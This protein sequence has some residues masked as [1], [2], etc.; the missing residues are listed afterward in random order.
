MRPLGASAWRTRFF[1]VGIAVFA[2]FF[3]FGVYDAAYAFLQRDLPSVGRLE[4]WEPHL[5]T[6]VYAA[7]GSLLAEF[8]SERREMVPL[9]EVPPVVVK[10]LLATEDQW[11]YQH[12]GI[13]YVRLVEAAIH[14]LRTGEA[15]QGASTITQQLARNLFLTPE[16]KLTRKI[17]E[18][19]LA[20]E[21]EA[22]YD[23]DE[24]LEMYLN[25]VYFGSGAYGIESA[26]NLYFGKPARELTLPEAALLVGL[27][28]APGRYS[29][30][31]DLRA[32]IQRRNTV[33]E[34]MREDGLVDFATTR[35]AQAAPIVL[36]QT[37]QADR[38][39]TYF[40][41]YVRSQIEGLF[42]SEAVW[43]E[44][45]RVYTTLDPEL[46]AHAEKV[47][48]QRSR[49]IE[50]MGGFRAYRHVTREQWL[51]RQTAN[52]EAV[53]E[54]AER[55]ETD[56]F[57][58]TPYLQMGLVA[59]DLETGSIRAM[60][61]GRS[62]EESKFNRITQARRQPGSTFKPFVY[63]AAIAGG[64]PA[65]HVIYDVPFAM[66][67]AD[68]TWWSPDN[69]DGTFHGAMPLREAL[70]RSI[71]VVAVKLQQQIG[72]NAVLQYA[73]D[74]GL[75][76]PLPAVPSLAIGAGEVIP[77]EMAAAYTVYPNLGVKVEPRAISRIEDRNGV[78]LRSFEPRRRRVLDRRAAYL[79]LTI[80]RDVVD[81]GTG[82]YGLRGKGFTAPAG[83]KTG[84]TNESTDSWFVG[85]TPK[86]LTLV[87]LG[88]DRKQKIMH[89]GTG[90][91][92]AAPT[93]TAFMEKVVERDSV[94]GE[95]PSADALGLKRV[96]V[97]R[98]S[99]LLAAPFCN[100]AAYTELFIPGTEPERYCSPMAYVEDFDYGPFAGAP[101][102][103][104][105]A[106]SADSLAGDS[107]GAAR[108]EP[109]LPRVDETY[110][111]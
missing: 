57:T 44:G 25:Q 104:L 74:S 29:P 38:P 90:G 64:I 94:V 60:V 20:R 75:S 111:F 45:L 84:T 49:E 9:E 22:T 34:G 10:A 92:L 106:D 65:S 23:K 73:R 30:R 16:K 68:G 28:K 35:R 91:L 102:D 7:D 89:N 37:R 108:P 96:T 79:M 83:G 19:V 61:G 46:Q 54:L 80:L 18:A 40:A 33:L 93:W 14:N 71:N 67:E 88:F 58:N 59:L 48:E 77:L 12:R 95:F 55:E 27:P 70:T 69:F 2:L 41:D 39:S 8:A 52:P 43:Q 63:A 66:R 3:G 21:I 107:A 98:S 32:A 31:V 1:A 13:N 82:R 85:F 15:A 24:I 56:E 36:A 110:D 78:L 86:T 109:P 17:K 103:P 51:A 81:K 76:T 26:A 72:T 4:K 11:F 6:K 97:A 105:A 100:S 53:E 99:G 47:V 62:F 87:W 101:P 42:G 50:A 5:T